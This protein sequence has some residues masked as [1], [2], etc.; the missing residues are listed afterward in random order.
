MYT[1]H[2]Y[3]KRKHPAY[4]TDPLARPFEDMKNSSD[5]KRVTKKSGLENGSGDVAGTSLNINRHHRLLTFIQQQQS[6]GLR[7]PNSVTQLKWFISNLHMRKIDKIDLGVR[8]LRCYFNEASSERKFENN[9]NLR[10][11]TFTLLFP[12]SLQRV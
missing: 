8:P 9:A 7:F 5:H 10:L 2:V 12:A 3:K 4:N 1:L 11:L 6:L